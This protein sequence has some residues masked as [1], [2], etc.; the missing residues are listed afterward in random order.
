MA[1]YFID[2]TS[3]NVNN[4]SVVTNSG[5]INYVTAGADNNDVVYR[6]RAVSVSTT[7]V[8]D[9]FDKYDNRFEPEHL[10]D[11]DG[12]NSGGGS[13]PHSEFS[14]EFSNEFN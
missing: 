3:A 6:G 10:C 14:S 1:L 8:D 12:F 2:N 5:G 11:V 7:L 4:G 13:G 9:A